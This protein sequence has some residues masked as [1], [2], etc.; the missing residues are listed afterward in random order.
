MTGRFN[1]D[2]PE[3]LQMAFEKATNYKPRIITKQSINSRKVHTRTMAVT[4]LASTPST[5]VLPAFLHFLNKL[6]HC[7]THVSVMI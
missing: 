2:L 3:N 6:F 1:Q 7:K 4:R 5:T